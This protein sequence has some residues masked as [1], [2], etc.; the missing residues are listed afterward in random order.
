[1]T[2]PDI[3]RSDSRT[4]LLRTVAAGVLMLILVATIGFGARALGLGSGWG[5]LAAAIAT[6]VF[7]TYV[8]LANQRMK[9]RRDKNRGAR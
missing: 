6:P 9:D 1:M 7:I 4:M 8:L 2:K 5:L 3:S